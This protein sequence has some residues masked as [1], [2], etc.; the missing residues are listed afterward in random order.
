VTF[1]YLLMRYGIVPYTVTHPIRA[2]LGEVSLGLD[3]FEALGRAFLLFLASVIAS[4]VPAYKLANKNLLE[5]IW[6]K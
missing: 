4:V 5:L 3:I 1:G 6:E 2:P